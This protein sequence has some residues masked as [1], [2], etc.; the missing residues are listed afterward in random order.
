[1]NAMN[2]NTMNNM[3]QQ[4][5]QQNNQSPNPNQEPI[6]LFVSRNC[7][8]C[9]DVIQA[10]QQK[11]QLA[12]LVQVVSV[13]N[14]PRLPEGLSKVPALIVQGKILM[15]NDCFQYVQKHGELEASPTYSNSAGYQ[16]DPYSYINES[17]GG[18]PQGTESYSY[19]GEQ[20][21]SSGIDP[22][23]ID[24]FHQQEMAQK[25]N[26]RNTTSMNMDALEQQRRQE[27]SQFQ[28]SVS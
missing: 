13:E 19:I 25:S 11:P 27:F 4:Q 23:K 2:R 7:K 22:S 14:V 28:Q 9:P 17:S 12:K 6:Y 5:Q 8:H 21:G 1:M 3:N 18:G 10:I 26:T 24:Q 15:G 16:V 20:T